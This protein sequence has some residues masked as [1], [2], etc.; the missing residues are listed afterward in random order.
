MN[1]NVKKG[2]FFGILVGFAWGLDTVLMGMVGQNPILQGFKSSA[3]VSAFL[4]DGFCFFWLA[5]V[6]FFRKELMGVFKLLKTKKGKVSL[7]AAVVGAPI[8]MSG[9]VIGIKY[10]APAY[11]SSISVIYPG[12]GAILSY[13]ILKEKL[14]MRAVIGITISLIGSAALGYSKVDLSLYP[15]FY[16]GMAFTCIAVLGWAFEGVIIGYAMKKIKDEDNIK[17][18]PQQF[19]TVRYLTSFAVYALVIMPAV[20]G[21]PVVAKI[22][23]SRDILY[24]A[25]IAI[26]GATT[27]LSWYKAVDYIGAAM[28]TALNSTAAFWAIIFSWLILGTEITPYLAI[29]GAIIIVGVFIFA[30]N[31]NDFKKK[32]NLEVK[33]E[34]N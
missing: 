1:N 9:Y 34:N 25:G 22:A 10:A 16:K 3:L 18:S 26:L 21:Y 33:I 4:H 28:G 5:V 8:G 2:L 30:I 32:K 7:L 15:N 12:V 14:S 24:F 27:Y 23:Q 20:G 6:M 29:C 17:A 19:L 11:A 13:F 31:P